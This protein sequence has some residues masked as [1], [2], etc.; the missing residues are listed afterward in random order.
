MAVAT[1]T[2]VRIFVKYEDTREFSWRVRECGGTLAN[3]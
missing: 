1:I 3:L 2:K